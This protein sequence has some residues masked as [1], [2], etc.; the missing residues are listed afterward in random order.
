M[1]NSPDT[2]SIHILDDDSLLNIFYLYRPAILDGVNDD[3]LCMLGGKT[4]RRE[5]WWYK[6]AQVC[7]R[8]RTLILGSTSHLGLC[9]VCT[10]GTPIADMLAHSPPLPLIIDYV[11]WEITAKDEEGIILALA[12]RNRVRRIRFRMRVP[13]LQ[14]LIMAI[15]EEYPTLE[16]LILV[17]PMDMSTTL[18]LPETLQA[19]HLRHLLLTGFVLPI[20]SQLLVTAVGLVT[21]TLI[22]GHPPTYFQP[23]ILLRWLS[24]MSQLETLQ[25]GLFSS[26]FPNH[27]VEG[28]LMYMPITTHITLPNLRRFE[29]QGEGASIEDVIR[30]ISAPRLKKVN[31]WFLKQL[32][33][34][35]PRLLQFIN[36]TQDLRFCAAKFKFSIDSV[37]V[38]V[39]PREAETYA[40]SLK[41]SCLHLDWQVSSA[42]QICNPPSQI[43]ST[44][45]HLTLEHEAHSLSS[46][47]HNEVDRAE[48]RKF[49]KSFSNVKTLRFD[50]GLVKELSRCL[51]LDDGEHPLELLP[52][53]QEL[54]YSGRVKMKPRKR[55]RRNDTSDAFAPF[56]KAR[57]NAGHAVTLVYP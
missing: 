42:A 9:L 41:V 28:Q 33:F 11:E 32:T 47:E 15:N 24:F 21:L 50:A 46:Q 20:G 48:W 57:Q 23:K 1:G 12:Q 30:W 37:H 53:L 29:F 6:L 16:Y 17:P 35:V 7:Q 38:E 8:W 34:S 52:E 22:A 51:R 5:R 2:E 10:H 4:W 49:L 27:G 25:L 36:T 45:E 54:R 39:Y 19:P 44:V 3:S 55:R 40:L 31:I 43:F 13:N 26:P 18:M 14:K 56:I